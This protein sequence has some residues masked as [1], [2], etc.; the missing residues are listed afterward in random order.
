MKKWKCTVCGYIHEGEEPPEKC[1]VCG[2]DKSLFEELVE[3]KTVEKPEPVAE[4][5]APEPEV[6]AAAVTSK[7]S[8]PQA[9]PAGKTDKLSEMIVKN[10]IHPI[11]VHIPNGVLPIT[12]LFTMIA[13]I[14]G[15]EILETAAICNMTIIFLAMPAVLY[16]GYK[17]WQHKYK[18][19]RTDLFLTKLVCGVLVTLLA[20][21]LLI[22]WIIDP[23]AATK[24]GGAGWIFLL[25]H[26]AMLLFAAIAGFMGGKL[27]FRD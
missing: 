11:T 9:R 22:W 13:L 15:C 2:A 19:A 25:L 24:G 23:N 8:A 4:T 12:V 18:G 16:T 3:E 6:A 26:F 1:P 14:F 10:H 5:T 20:V 27:V 21:F 7:D 17:N